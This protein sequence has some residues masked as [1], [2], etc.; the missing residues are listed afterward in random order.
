[1]RVLYLM[2]NEGYTATDGPRLPRPDLVAEALRLTRMLRAS[3]PGEPEVAGLLSLMLLTDSRRRSRTGPAGELIPLDEQDRTLWDR[4]LLSE[5]V[6]ILT[7]AL[8]QGRVGAY[9]LQASIAAAHAAAPRAAD[10]DWKQILGLHGLLRQLDDD[11]V[12]ALNHTVAFAMV[13][14]AK[15]D[16]KA[17]DALPAMARHHRAAAVRAHP[18]ER[19]RQPEAAATWFRKAAA[20]TESLA[21]RN[22]LLLRA[23]RLRGCAAAR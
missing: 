18:L 14:G 5:G 16:L 12:V 20:Q 13:H 3:R 8:Q 22:Y 11:P 7:A 21:E 9:Q 4:A 1:M 10:S 2:F 15:A 23:A 19:A 6:R 17:L